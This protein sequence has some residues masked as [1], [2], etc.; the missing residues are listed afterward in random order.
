MLSYI[1]VYLAAAFMGY[2]IGRLGHRYLNDWL[3]NPKWAIHH[4]IYGFI[5]MVVGL[6]FHKE[7]LGL[8][9][10]FFGL[11]DFISDLK[12]FLQLKFIGPD[13]KIEKKFWGI[14]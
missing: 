8:L 13:D 12:D 2:L 9:A 10:F 4:W 5:L 14:N 11:G 1:F 6:I 3:R 7:P